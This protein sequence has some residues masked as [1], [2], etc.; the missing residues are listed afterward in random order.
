MRRAAA[1]AS[2]STGARSRCAPSVLTDDPGDGREARLKLRINEL[3][4]AVFELL[5]G[6]DIALDASRHSPRTIPRST[7]SGNFGRRS[8]SS[9]P[10]RTSTLRKPT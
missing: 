10:L 3:P 9:R 1:S 5:D 4:L 2:R 7:S 6:Q 8:A